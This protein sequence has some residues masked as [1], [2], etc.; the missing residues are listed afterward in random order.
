MQNNHHTTQLL[1][2][3]STRYTVGEYNTPPKTTN[4]TK[5]TMAKKNK[6]HR[7]AHLR[8][9]NDLQIHRQQNSLKLNT[10]G[11]SKL[12]NNVSKTN[13][14]TRAQLRNIRNH[15]QNHLNHILR[16]AIFTWILSQMKIHLQVSSR[17]RKDGYTRQTDTTGRH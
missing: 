9:I 5:T 1:S 13:V 4:S 12:I 7:K 6:Q 3:T 11:K 10:K 15:R 16:K 8:N 17:A 14:K 2:T